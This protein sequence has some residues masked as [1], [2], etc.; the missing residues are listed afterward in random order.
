MTVKPL[1]PAEAKAA[2]QFA[3]PNDVIFAV[4]ELLSEKVNLDGS[5]R[6]DQN[7]IINRIIRRMAPDPELES[8]SSLRAK[9]FEMKW[10]DFE[11]VYEAEGW[12]VRYDKPAYCETYTAFWVFTP[13][14][15]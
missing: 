4:N 6:F 5:V 8:A 13:K 11:P 14:K 3:I 1:S 12:N 10:L 15:S 9:I 7:E 2:K